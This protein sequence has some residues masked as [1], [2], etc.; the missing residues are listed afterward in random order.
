MSPI[1]L[2][3][4][5]LAILALPA[6]AVT[7]DWVSVGD[8]NNPA[9]PV[10]G[11]GAVDHHYNIGKHEVTLGQ[12]TEF[13]NS[14]AASDPHYLYWTSMDTNLSTAGIARSGSSGSYT[15]NVIG[16]PN[17][18]ASFVD[19][20]SAARMANWMHNGQGNGRTETGAYNLNGASSGVFARQAAAQVWIPNLDEWHKA[21]YYSGTGDS[22]WLYPTQ[23]NSIPSND[24]L[25][26]G[27]NVNYYDSGYTLATQNKLTD[28]GSFPESASHYGT[29]DQG[30]NLMEWNEESIGSAHNL[31]GGGWNNYESAMRST[32]YPHFDSSSRENIGFR[33]ASIPEP[34]AVL[35]LVFGGVGLLLRRKRG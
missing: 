16:S 2:S 6:A 26:A 33:L 24:I 31:R 5:F 7:I 4:T 25:G 1:V 12:Y 8:V 17:R 15:Y 29:F 14:T 19:W 21:A 34:S 30:G 10:A 20:F 27:N 32:K 28:V 18:P 13:L 3:A 9:D 11:Y 22:Y 35:L 23:S